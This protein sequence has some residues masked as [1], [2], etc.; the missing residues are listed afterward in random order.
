MLYKKP[1]AR[2]KEVVVVK[3]RKTKKK[4]MQ[5]IES[6]HSYVQDGIKYTP[7]T[8][9]I[10]SFV[11]YVDWDKMCRIKAAK[12]GIP[13]Q[14]LRAQW[15]KTRDDASSK[16][17]AYHKKK[18]LEYLSNNGIVIEDTLCPVVTAPT[19]KGVKNDEDMVLQNNT[20][21]VE[22]MV[23]N[24]EYGI[25]GTADLVEVVNGKVYVKD[26]KTNT[27]L[28]F[29]GF[30]G[31]KMKAPVSHLQD[32][33]YNHYQ[34]QLNTYMYMLLQ[35]NRHLKFGGMQI[36]HVL[37]DED[38]NYKE[39]KVYNV[40]KMADVIKKMMKAFKSKRR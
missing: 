24:T 25:C 36:L 12:L 23:W 29:Q 4:K 10:K 39:T 26:Y 11:P 9:F 28:K 37:F 1:T 40:E 38:G 16:G 8:Y 20:V 17:T 13:F 27:E 3:K 19:K 7:V 32:C 35:H 15:N 22:K 18:E 30:K 31:A 2:T 33:N 14:E 21:Y 34:L 6:E 5:F